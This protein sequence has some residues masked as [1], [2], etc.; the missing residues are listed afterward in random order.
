MEGHMLDF[1]D[2]RS[3][4]LTTIGTHQNSCQALSIMLLW[5]IKVLIIHL[6]VLMTLLVTLLFL[7]GC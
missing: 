3:V 4:Y 5:G 7:L 1:R 6:S 2:A